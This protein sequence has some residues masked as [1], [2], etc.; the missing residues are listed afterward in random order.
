MLCHA[1]RQAGVERMAEVY[2]RGSPG[3][4]TGLTSVRVHTAE[5]G[6]GH[7]RRMYGGYGPI[8]CTT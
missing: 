5:G 2:S 7:A 3:G 6:P 8:V 1:G 4:E